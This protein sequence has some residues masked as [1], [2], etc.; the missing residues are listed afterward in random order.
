MR[1]TCHPG[2]QRKNP[3]VR[4]IRRE[5]VADPSET[6]ARSPLTLT[7]NCAIIALEKARW[8]MWGPKHEKCR[9]CGTTERRHMARGYCNPCYQKRYHRKNKQRINQITM[10][11]YYKDRKANPEKYVKQ[12]ELLYHN[13]NRRKV[14]RRD[15]F[16]CRKCGY[17]S[18]L[19]NHSDLVCHHK[20]MTGRE[21]PTRNHDTKLLITLCRSCHMNVHFQARCIARF[22]CEF[23][24]WS[25]K[26]DKCK[27]C[28]ETKRKH[29]AHGMCWN[30]YQKWLTRKHARESREK[31]QSNPHSDVG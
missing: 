18:K 24:G 5:V 16:T 11:W 28:S 26:Y 7:P 19:P 29:L 14:L 8:P 2:T 20:D 4:P 21:S 1:G 10:E 13:G 22:G 12:R 25:A 17:K 9:S 23:K 15:K 6:C 3:T 27:V 30:C 31:I